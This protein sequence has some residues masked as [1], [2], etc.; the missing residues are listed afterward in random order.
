M[1]HSPV[2]LHG[3]EV[4]IELAVDLSSEAFLNVL[5][6]FISKRGCP[7][8]IYSDNGLNFIGAERELNELT[9]LINDNK[10]QIK[11]NDYASNH[12]IRWHISPRAPHHGSL[13]EAAVKI[14]KRH[15]S[16]IIKNAHLRYEELETLLVQIEAILNSRPIIPVLFDPKNLVFLTPGYFVIGALS[17]HILKKLW[18]ECL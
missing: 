16:K 17:L 11:I 1:L 13:W 2:C 3:N 5:K 7:S 12:G 8:N 14:V 4:H 10:M 18:R 9:M 15:L 6:R